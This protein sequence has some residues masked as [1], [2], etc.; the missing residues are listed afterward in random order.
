MHQSIDKN[1]KILIYLIFLIILSTT[2]N[3]SLEN[4]KNYSVKINKIIVSGLSNDNNFQIT[5]KLNNLLFR[6]IFFIDKNYINTII[7]EYNLIE[8]YSVKKIYPKQVNI[9]IEKT[10]YIAEIKGSSQFLIGSNGKLISNEYTDMSLPL[11]FGK[12]NSKK[13]LKFKISIEKSEFKFEDFK[14]IFFYF[15]NRWDVQT[16]DGILIRLP[17]EDL[18]EALSIAHKIIKD[19]KFKGNRVIDLRISNHVIMKNEK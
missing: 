16:I 11:F 15:S 10:K 4:K 7:S 19:D 3:K 13:F 12:F 18:A 6:N 9:K 1:K 14:S 17:K 2:S 8:K 5:E